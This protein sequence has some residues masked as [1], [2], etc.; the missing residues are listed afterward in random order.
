MA[1]D[2]TN[3]NVRPLQPY[4]P[5]RTNS[6]RTIIDVCM[7]IFNN[8]HQSEVLSIQDLNNLLVIAIAETG[9]VPQHVQPGLD[10]T[11]TGLLQMTNEAFIQRL[12]DLS[13]GSA[14]LDGYTFD[15]N[16]IFQPFTYSGITY[17]T[18]A[19]LQAMNER[20]SREHAAIIAARDR[21]EDTQNLPRANLDAR[22]AWGVTRLDR[23]IDDNNIGNQDVNIRV[24]IAEYLNAK[25]RTG[26]D[27]FELYH[28]YHFGVNT[29]RQKSTT[30]MGRIYSGILTLPTI[31]ERF[32]NQ[33]NDNGSELNN[34]DIENLTALLSR[35][36]SHGAF[37][38]FTY[39]DG[40]LTVNV[41]GQNATNA[42][43]QVDKILTASDGRNTLNGGALADILI[44]GNG[45]DRLIGGGGHDRLYGGAGH[46]LLDGSAGD[47]H[48]YGGSGHDRLVGGAGN[49]TYYFDVTTVAGMQPDLII[50]DAAGS[51]SIVFQTATGPVTLSGGARA[52][53]APENTFIDNGNP[54]IRYRFQPSAGN[55][56]I[57][58]LFIYHGNTLIT[59]VRDF[60]KQ[61]RQAEGAYLGLTLTDPGERPETAPLSSFEQKGRHVQISAQTNTDSIVTIDLRVGDVPN[62]QNP[63]L[64]TGPADV[65][66]GSSGSEKVILGYGND[67]FSGNGGSDIVDGGAGHD[68][69]IVG[70][71]AVPSESGSKVTGGTGQDMIIGGSG[72]DVLIAGGSMHEGGEEETSGD[73]VA[74]GGGNDRIYGSRNMDLLCGG[75]GADFIEGNGGSDVII[76]DARFT[77]S[78]FWV[79]RG[80]EQQSVTVGS[81]GNITP[82]QSGSNQVYRFPEWQMRITPYTGGGALYEYG[83]L[84]AGR[85]PWLLDPAADMASSNDLLFGGAGND[86]IL[87]QVGD[88]IIDGGV[89]ND[90]LFGDGHIDADAN[91]NGNILDSIPITGGIDLNGNDIIFGG[92]GSDSIYGGRGNDILYADATFY[93]TDPAA[94]GDGVQDWLDGGEGDDHLYGGTGGDVLV[95]GAGNDHLYAGATATGPGNQLQGGANNDVLYSNIG[96]HTLL[97]GLGNDAY[98]Y[99][100]DI[101]R[102]N[103]ETGRTDHIWD[104]YEGSAPDPNSTGG[105]DLDWVLIV[106][107]HR[108]TR[109][110]MES[111][112]W[113]NNTLTGRIGGR[114]FQIEHRD[115][116]YV[117]NYLGADGRPEGKSIHIHGGLYQ[118]GLIDHGGRVYRV[119]SAPV[120]TSLSGTSGD[121]FLDGRAYALLGRSQQG[122]DIETYDGHDTVLGSEYNDYIDGGDGH[123]YLIG[124]DGND[125]IYG[126]AG[127]DYL[128]GLI[129]DDHL[130]GGSGN[131]RLEGGEGND[132]LIGGEGDDVILGGEGGDT[133]D[134]GEGDD[135]LQ[136]GDGND[137]I[138]G[139]AGD[140]IVY[141]EA[142]DDEVYGGEGDDHLAG[143]DGHDLIHGGDGDD[144]LFGEAGNDELYGGAGSNYLDG[145]AGDDL[146][147][148]GEG[149]DVYVFARGYGRDTL[150]DSGGGNV[151]LLDGLNPEDIEL[152]PDY[153]SYTDEK[154]SYDLIIRIKATGE[155]LTVINGMMSRSNPG[156]PHGNTVVQFGDNSLV[157]LEDLF[158]PNWTLPYDTGQ[159][160]IINGDRGNNT[161]R[162][163]SGHDY[164]YGDHGNDIIYGLGGNDE[165][166][167]NKGDDILYGGSGDDIIYG[168]NQL[169]FPWGE[170]QA[171][172]VAGHDLTD[173]PATL[174]FGYDTIYGGDG[175]DTLMGGHSGDT[176]YGGEGDDEIYGGYGWNGYDIYTFMQFDGDDKLYGE[177]GNDRIYGNRGNDKIYG[178]D[179]DDLMSGG[180]GDDY[181]EGGAGNDVYY[182]SIDPTLYSYYGNDTINNFD[183]DPSSYDE[184]R[185]EFGYNRDNLILTRGENGTDLIISFINTEYHPDSITVSKHFDESG[186]WAIDGLRFRDGTVL[187][188]SEIDRIANNRA[189]EIIGGLADQSGTVGQFFS[190][191]IPAGLFSDPDGDPLSYRLT[192]GD[193]SIAPYWL[194][195]DPATMTVSGTAPGAFDKT[196]RLVASD[197]LRGES[198]IE[199]GL[200]VAYP[201]NNAPE[202]N[203]GLADQSG[204]AGEF[205]SFVI[206]TGL[207]SDADG[208][209]LS[210]RLTL[211]DGCPLPPWLTF[212][213]ATMTV[214]GKAPG[215]FNRVLNLEVSDGRGGKVSAGFGLSI[216]PQPANQAPQLS[217]SISSLDYSEEQ[218]FSFT[219]PVNMFTDPDGDALTYR[220][221]LADGQSLPSWL[222]FDA[223]KGI[224]SGICP[225]S[226]T[227]Q[228]LSIRLWADDGRK[229]SEALLF[230]INF[231]PEADLKLIVGTE[232]GETLTGTS[233]A[234]GLRGLGGKDNLY[235]YAGN[236]VLDGGDDDDRLE[237]G[238][239]DDHLFG[240]AGNDTLDGGA[241]DDVY[242]FGRGCGHDT[243]KASSAAG[244]RDVIRF[245]GLNRDEV[246]FFSDLYD[247]VIRIKDTG[248]TITALNV[249][250][251]YGQYPVKALVFADGQVVEINGTDSLGQIEV[252][253]DSYGRLSASY[254]NSLLNGSDKDDV[255]NGNNGNDVLNGGGGQDKLYG[256]WGD[257]RLFGGDGND[258]LTGD[259]GIDYLYGEADDDVLR[260]GWG[261]DHLYGGAGDDNLDGEMDDD[262]LYGEEGNDLLNGGVGSDQL[263]GGDG[264]DDLRGYDGDDLL[265][266]GRGDDF[267]VGGRGNDTYVFN[268]GD[269]HDT[270]VNKQ[271][272]SE[273]YFGEYQPYDDGHDVLRLGE[274]I[275]PEDLIFER[276]ADDHGWTTHLVIKFRNSPSD[277]ITILNQLAADQDLGLDYVEFAGDRVLS[278]NDILNILSQN[279]YG[280][281]V[282][283]SA[284]MGTGG[285]DYLSAYGKG[286]ARSFYGY[287]G[288]DQ[289]YGG[290]NDDYIDGG[291]GNDVLNG[292]EGND[293]LYG[294]E[295]NDKLYGG[296]GNDT[297]TGGEG[298]DHLDGGWDDDLL[299]GGVGNDFLEGGYGND[300]LY[301]GEGDDHL[302]GGV[303]DDFLDGGAGDDY[304][305]GG[306]GNDVFIFGRGYG[307]D[308]ILILNQAPFYE[309]VV[310]RLKDL[311]LSDVVFEVYDDD[312]YNRH[313]IIRIKD[314][315]E[316]VI[317]EHCFP[318]ESSSYN[319]GGPAYIQFADGSRLT[320]N[321]LVSGHLQLIPM[322][323]SGTAGDDWINGDNG[324]NILEGGRGNDR[325]DGGAG[326]DVYI[327]NRG[328]GRDEIHNDDDSPG[329]FDVIRFGQG[330]AAADLTFQRGLKGSQLTDDLIITIDG[331]PLDKIIVKNYFYAAANW[332]IDQI[333]LADGTV[334]GRDGILARLITDQPDQ[335][336]GT[337]NGEVMQGDEYDNRLSGQDGDD[338]LKG[339]DGNDILEGGRGDDILDGGAGSDVYIFNPGDGRDIINNKEALYSKSLD[340]LRFGAGITAS[341]LMVSLGKGVSGYDLII[342]FRNNPEDK[343]TI[344]GFVTSSSLQ[345]NFY[346]VRS[347]QF[348]DGTVLRGDDLLPLTGLSNS[349]DIYYGGNGNDQLLG[350]D[351]NDSLYGGRGD[352]YLEG[353]NGNDILYG[354]DDND[355]LDGGSG[356]DTLYGE[357]G[358]DHMIGGYGNDTLYGGSGNDHLYGG[359]GDDILYGGAGD[360]YLEGTSGSDVYLFNPGDGRDV[361]RDGGYGIVRFGVDVTL[362]D[363]IM[364]RTPS[365]DSGADDDLV[366]SFHNNSDDR[367][368]IL[369]FYGEKNMSRGGGLEFADGTIHWFNNKASNDSIKG[370]NGDDVF[371]F[372]RGDG[373]D[374]LTLNDATEGKCDALHLRGLTLNDLT[375]TSFTD[376]NYSG[377]TPAVWTNLMITIK[378]TGEQLTI[379][380]GIRKDTSA[381]NLSG[382]EKIILDDGTEMSFEDFVSYFGPITVEPR[383][384]Y[385][386]SVLS[387]RT[388]IYQYNSNRIDSIFMV[389]ESKWTTNNPITNPL[390]A[391]YYGG[392][393]NNTYVYTKEQ[394]MNLGI[395]S[396]ITGSGR[397]VLQLTDLNLEDLEFSV[398]KGRMWTATQ[399]NDHYNIHIT[400]AETGKMITLY[401]A[402]VD[403]GEDYSCTYDHIEFADGSHLSLK[404]L[405]ELI[406][407]FMNGS[408]RDDTILASWFNTLVKAGS[409][410]DKVTG[411][412]G[413]DEIYGDGGNDTLSG[414]AGD[415]LLDGGTG[416]DTLNGGAGSDT[417][418]WGVGY[419]NDTI[420]ASDGTVVETDK[421]DVLRL[422][423]VGYDDLLFSAIAYNSSSQSL[424]ITIR[425]T[426]ETLTIAGAL[427]YNLGAHNQDRLEAI[428]FADGTAMTW[429]EFVPPYFKIEGTAG[430]DTLTASN[431]HTIMKGVAGDD[432]L[433][434]GAGND[435]LD[436]GT[437]N[438]TLD[439]KAGSD[440][441]IFGRGYG[442]DTINSSDSTA[443]KRDV[444]RLAGLA[445]GDVEFMVKYVS[446]SYCNL[447]IR[448]KD[449][450]E[451][452]T[453]VNAIYYTTARN[454]YSIEA[455]EFGDGTIMEW[456]ELESAGLIMMEGTEAVDS[457][458]AS[459]LGTKMYGYGGNDT[460]NGGAGDD[461]LYGGLGNDTLNSNAGSDALYGED[462]DD[463]LYGGASDD[464]LDGGIGN[465][466]LDGG[467]GNDVYVFGRGYGYDTISSSDTT[468]GKR[469]VVR[470]IGLTLAEVEFSTVKNG[471]S[472]YN[473]IIR[474][475]DTGETLT[476]ANA[477]YSSTSRNNYSI[478]AIEFGDGTTLGWAELETS[479]LLTV[480][481]TEAAET[482]DASRLGSTMYGYGGNDRLN[483]GAGDDRLFG[484]N[485]N[486]ALYGNAGIDFLDGGA[487]NDTLDGGAGSDIY[488][489]GRGYGND[490][491]SSSDA[492]V[493]KRD[494]VRL[495][496]LTLADVELV[497]VKNGSYY[498]NLVIRIKD[499]GETLTVLN[500]IYY[501]TAR[502]N[503]SIEAIEFGDGSVLEWADLE[504]SGLLMMAG[505]EAVD[506][507]TASRLGTSMYG[508][509]GNDTLAGGAGHDILYGGEGNDTM[510]GNAGNDI[511]D[512]GAGNDTLNG[513]AGDD[514][515]V[516]G[517][518]Y[519]YDTI[520]SSDST[521]GKRDVVRLLGVSLD[522]V[523]FLTVKSSSSNYHNLVI[524]IKDTG[525]ALTVVNAIY[526]TT[527]TN[528]YRIEAIEFGDGT[529]LEWPELELAGLIKME[530]GTANDSLAASRL[531]TAMYGYAGT[532]T[533]TGGAGHDILYGGEGNDT[534]NGGAGNDLLDG[535]SANDAL[536]GG[537]GD[538]TYIFRS[539]AG[540]DTITNTGGGNDLLK[541]TDIDPTELWFGKSGNHLIISLIG[542]T[543]K[544]T[545]NNWYS[546]SLGTNSID[547]IEAGDSYLVESQVAQLVQ[548]M[549]TVGA[550][551]GAGG[552]WTDEQREAL[553]P[554]LNT[555]WQ[556][557]A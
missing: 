505:T 293:T 134:G 319:F 148:G 453:V 240:G 334:I 124:F 389:D 186:N 227:G 509:A 123:D 143:G 235:G 213:Q 349:D 413:D 180:T 446:S 17:N 126:G 233:G 179:G 278:R 483:G 122:L 414:G 435:T 12:S 107:G 426:G 177:G 375:L 364:A 341:D 321:Q 35:E 158:D 454:N 105:G 525:E 246:E 438:D 405:N 429:D 300:T 181:M 190:F 262:V 361:I 210:Y 496:G 79:D 386:G 403:K 333:K 205:F 56:N 492:T 473:L 159:G 89:G 36:I 340:T 484:G 115:G 441:Y 243:I 228:S 269:G 500:A 226:P 152:L 281:L 371:T 149:D 504:S 342:T 88:D 232:G 199:F 140:D 428:E 75:T 271:G 178:G 421:R 153:D 274:G 508:Y 212:D 295:G 288:S 394:G 527:A 184:I 136:G 431:Y 523:D 350:F 261:N 130:D 204:A 11:A 468:V 258:S 367:I 374:R 485:D 218:S 373:N 543:D 95:G 259:G 10:S 154:E 187:N 303:G 13:L 369:G 380:S 491:I 450:G 4:G 61:V 517:R 118:A 513:G 516:F 280:G 147:E 313:L 99:S 310:L 125:E 68:Y 64:G 455:I 308:R 292:D 539:G 128:L 216:L 557:R 268:I 206:P 249:L 7:S 72:D 366:I 548:A 322:I 114:S 385:N 26:N 103:G 80:G 286:V 188:R 19:E 106:D 550:P 536:N 382:L 97:G 251:G 77:V 172:V 291:T 244:Q 399:R 511:L 266:G 94:A 352:D 437:G 113:I 86:L 418:I 96:A 354:G 306:S 449:T 93:D 146:L 289:I 119:G 45:T 44:G 533:L 277:S 46:D 535:G 338:D 487:G 24:A 436:G 343:V 8:N 193:G 475:K 214:S 57:G 549:A 71:P 91:N 221:T 323:T 411:G 430:N 6:S 18:I 515:Y 372:G 305:E 452:L 48:L 363:L 203:G 298:D 247:L 163:G 395:T 285:E 171:I 531:D 518:G 25:A 416:N 239:G 116:D 355:Q 138:T 316:T 142:G 238:D 183:A 462:G 207:F 65:V 50:D 331:E 461:T 52:L 472:Y 121:D 197:G 74:G 328:D 211:D 16:S 512:G 202:I 439:G 169:Y 541:F 555:Y 396:D 551:G 41:P 384:T 458:T 67:Y 465:D 434:G 267:L 494:V 420:F 192:L 256:G 208:D 304:L 87:G 255:L 141:A 497:T 359:S 479:G 194:K 250:R 339:L 150:I 477:I 170:G 53:N 168:D 131:D 66:I 195:F 444:V 412:V 42:P 520:S 109:G 22:N 474:I 425:S 236:D 346:S 358:D 39:R 231:N 70:D 166:A 476:V 422:T 254:H 83:V 108:I 318:L 263:Y 552:Q 447:I 175:N 391:E 92:A 478:E 362:E 514:I 336:T 102:A 368:T 198:S 273:F 378:E 297:L 209:A 353:G 546:G 245:E 27:I 279:G 320:W 467:A 2:S 540:Q 400:V 120:T 326:S 537:A 406:P 30:D 133:I 260:G 488:V 419:G 489:F 376:F 104:H 111:R 522:E 78:N 471:S 501:T 145:G 493:G 528:N 448:I 43:R 174:N 47:D 312:Y 58:S 275:R 347:F 554:M 229:Q 242:V 532:D 215:V 410:N 415:D 498:H 423:G 135:L 433:T 129:G 191:T 417:F 38:T 397:N 480:Y 33:C 407:F 270:I 15:V 189:P 402:V 464:L 482:M 408:E 253:P 185:F 401:N 325:L 283:E 299:H 490:T 499:T 60:N 137:I 344:T 387:T 173:A 98:V 101:L 463:K 544:V 360:D 534:L 329:R 3:V 176:V 272:Y 542:G 264:D 294:G 282:P 356:D 81:D 37:D 160:L 365:S 110:M 404:E 481:G 307:H 162:G 200:S 348:A 486:D 55:A 23:V 167:G 32:L 21:G 315:G 248:E 62:A 230:N 503:Y 442:H 383:I 538:D 241:G 54:N 223:E 1:N 20:A 370:H 69:I 398:T 553:T 432:K 224:F 327:F 155:T 381:P 161:L 330:I 51:G 427:K 201:P 182:Y 112:N 314:T 351:G 217:G 311:N 521:A 451:T 220:A 76:G 445:V 287:G 337:E 470:L 257:D 519:G 457:L 252:L 85:N 526:Y 284:I 222:N 377:Y 302:S 290:L 31:W 545:V 460:L 443:D 335:T 139:G 157:R 393:G 379:Y 466:I 547:R 388:V 324:A 495:L 132:T 219:I 456:A 317:I 59:V 28:R 165:I 409:G 296:N 390:Y 510:N 156:R 63:G 301:G 151:I 309:N 40:Q 506:S 144:N 117:F 524:R 82:S 29:S 502:N 225:A 440:V 469:D 276:L 265:A 424:V 459:R 90:I 164:I 234:D 392:I 5:T 530:G 100:G 34:S 507:L 556:P 49:D 237:G 529:V 345:A 73:I 332:A 14:Y 9:L 357:D 196:L 127:E 84:E